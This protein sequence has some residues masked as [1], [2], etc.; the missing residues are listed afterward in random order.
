MTAE[1]VCTRI[2]LSEVMRY[3]GCHGHDERAEQMAADS[4]QALSSVIRPRVVSKV[5]RVTQ[6]PD[7][8]L[9]DDALLIPGNDLSALLNG[10]DQA[11]L[12][13][14]TLSAQTD[15]FIRKAELSDLSNAL[16]LDS[17]ATAAVEVVCDLFE[18][19]LQSRYPDMKRTMRYSPGYG[20]VPI[21][22][23]EEFLSFLDA[24][25]KI[26]L[27]ATAS[28]ILTPRKSVTAIIGLS[29]TEVSHAKRSCETC[30]LKDHCQ[31]RQKGD[32]CGR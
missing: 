17:C 2:P 12:L 18:E 16:F 30:N 15:A 9:F 24:P 6:T 5:C 13:A 31:F 19:E 25:R 27:C 28:S 23:Q 7:G 3:A 32:F 21:T 8:C 1:R 26:G 11:A 29:K 10:C 14:C 4:I 20:D 22:V